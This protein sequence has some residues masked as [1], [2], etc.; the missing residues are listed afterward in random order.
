MFCTATGLRLVVES[1]TT[2]SDFR[3][4]SKYFSF[5]KKK[6]KIKIKN[7]KIIIIKKIKNKKYFVVEVDLL[8]YRWNNLKVFLWPG[9]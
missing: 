5:I 2:F 9:I 4:L 6:I 8:R 1:A 7:K 3:A